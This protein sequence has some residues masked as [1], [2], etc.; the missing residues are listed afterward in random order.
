M[1]QPQ[2]SS[3]LGYR[4]FPPPP[5]SG[6]PCLGLTGCQHLFSQ[7]VVEGVFVIQSVSFLCGF[8]LLP[9]QH[10]LLLGGLIGLFIA[11]DGPCDTG[12]FIGH[13]HRRHIA[14]SAFSKIR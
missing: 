10:R 3:L 5:Y 13:G 11:N 7:N 14:M 4:H 8:D 12:G 1:E 9:L 2:T 6:F